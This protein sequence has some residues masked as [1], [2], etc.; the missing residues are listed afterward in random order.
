MPRTTRNRWLLV[1]AAAAA[2][3]AVTPACRGKREVP[4][5]PAPANGRAHPTGLVLSLPD[6]IGGRRVTVDPTAT[7]YEVHCEPRNVRTPTRALVIFNAGIATPAGLW[8]QARTVRGATIRYSIQKLGG[9]IVGSGGPEYELRAWEPTRGGHIAYLQH[10]QTEDEPDFTLVW[11]V[12][13]GTT[14]P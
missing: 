6:T 3:V 13:A 10:V 5:A 2:L 11:A 9:D 4:P 12:I 8:P 1:G 14:R 7:G